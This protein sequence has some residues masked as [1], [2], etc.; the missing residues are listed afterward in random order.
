LLA[1]NHNGHFDRTESG[2]AVPIAGRGAAFGDLNND[3]WIDAVISVLGGHP[4][5]L[6]NRAAGNHH[7][8]TITLRGTKSNRDGYGARVSVNKQIRFAT[9]AGS[10][11]SAN[12]KRLHF[13][14][15]DAT[16]AAVE[17]LWPSGRR[18]SLTD[19]RV[20]QFLEIR[21]PEGS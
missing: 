16:V 3:G 11:V 4:L 13:G 9:S 21:E 7:W 2:V 1:L 12:D 15:G 8:L 5:V 6:M 18:Q 17:V 19:V 14:L 10:Y 20:D